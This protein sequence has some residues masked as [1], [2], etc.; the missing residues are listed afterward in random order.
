MTK[1]QAI[2]LRVATAEDTWAIRRLFQALHA[3][4]ASL[5]PRFELADDWESILDGHLATLWRTGDGEVTLAWRGDDPVGL[6]IMQAFVDAPLFKHRLWAELESIYVDPS[7]RGTPVAARL[8]AA[9][10]AWAR[11]RGYDRIQLFVT[12]SNAPAKRFYQHLGLNPVQEIWRL[13][14]GAHGDPLPEGLRRRLGLDEG[15]VG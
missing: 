4:N 1:N 15:T 2:T 13:D 11:A 9:G 10:T 5:D 7:A 8:V 6:L 12:A 14:L 3:Y